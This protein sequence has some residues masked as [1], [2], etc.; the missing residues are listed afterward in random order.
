MGGN[1]SP[2]TIDKTHRLL[3]RNVP[4]LFGGFIRMATNSVDD[5]QKAMPHCGGQYRPSLDQTLK[6]TDRKFDFARACVGGLGVRG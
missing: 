4:G 6:I 2:E 3:W 1:G 5:C